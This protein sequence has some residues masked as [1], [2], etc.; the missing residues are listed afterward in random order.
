MATYRYV[1]F[2][3]ADV[4]DSAYVD[5]VYNVNA[6]GINEYSANAISSVYPNPANTLIYID[7]NEAI[8]NPRFEIYSLLGNKVN[9]EV[10]FSQNGKVKIDVSNLQPGIYMLQELESQLTRKFIIS[11]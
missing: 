1:I 3:V 11:R 4:N 7:I 9:T 10:I 6:V 2:N 8:N 5:M